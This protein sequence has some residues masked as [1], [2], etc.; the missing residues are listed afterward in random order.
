MHRAHSGA[1]EEASK[2][3]AHFLIF[4]HSAQ[5]RSVRRKPNEIVTVG[6]TGWGRQGDATVQCCGLDGDERGHFDKARAISKLITDI[7]KYLL[8]KEYRLEL[9]LLDTHKQFQG[10]P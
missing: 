9:Q 7:N 1:R 8:G 5:G 10:M 3:N 4:Y 2:D 6:G